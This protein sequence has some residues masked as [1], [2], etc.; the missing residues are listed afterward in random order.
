MFVL[1]NKYRV[2]TLHS[3]SLYT[4]NFVL[5][6]Y[7]LHFISQQGFNMADMSDYKTE[8]KFISSVWETE[9]EWI[10]YENIRAKFLQAFNKH[11]HSYEPLQ[12]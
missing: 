10:S 9:A 7:F 5:K 1:Q 3:K 8:E 6:Q 4:E 2:G 12:T 11:A